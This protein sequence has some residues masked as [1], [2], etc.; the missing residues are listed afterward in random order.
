MQLTIR[1]PSRNDWADFYNNMISITSINLLRFAD[2][3][4]PVVLCPQA[5]ET[6]RLNS[7]YFQQSQA[8]STV[9]RLAALYGAVTLLGK[10]ISRLP[11]EAGSGGMFTTFHL[12]SSSLFLLSFS[13]ML[14]LSHI[15]ISLFYLLYHNILSKMWFCPETMCDLIPDSAGY[16]KDFITDK[17]Q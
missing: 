11:S 15:Y 7:W 17:T 10:W 2:A 6:I 12:L 13:S 5:S 1:G 3:T 8:N 16:F 9:S 4:S 14:S